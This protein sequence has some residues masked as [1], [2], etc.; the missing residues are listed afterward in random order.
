M[1]K[2]Y[3]IIVYLIT[4][5]LF[6][7]LFFFSQQSVTAEQQGEL[8]QKEK[9]I[10]MSF[11]EENPEGNVDLKRIFEEELARPTECNDPLMFCQIQDVSFDITIRKEW[12]KI[13]LAELSNYQ[14]AN[15]I[16]RIEN[17]VDQLTDSEVVILQETLARRGLLQY[18]DGST[19]HE[20]GFF[21]SLTGLA[22]TRLSH[23][24]GLSI[25]DPL[26]NELLRDKVNELLEN[27]ANDENY[28]NNRT[29]PSAEDM[30]PQE[31]DN[32]FESWKNYLYISDLAQ[33][34]DRVDT[35]NVH[36]DDNIDVNIEGFVNVERITE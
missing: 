30:T 15:T 20:R 18:L 14:Y 12:L 11:N 9:S 22:L 7:G 33:T 25:D 35:S 27:M 21:G 31:G 17:P 3:F 8:L 34:A 24:K 10:T 29:L 5:L 2:K 13:N 28:V 16:P 6:T 23:I 26:Y 32:L 4:I 19:V 1:N 36:L